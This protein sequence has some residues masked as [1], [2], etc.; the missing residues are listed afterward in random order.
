MLSFLFS[1]V[2]LL[3]ILANS[4]EKKLIELRAMTS[5]KYQK[6]SL[7]IKAFLLSIL[8]PIKLYTRLARVRVSIVNNRPEYFYF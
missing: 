2:T 6:A 1:K 4:K 7:V 3:Q 8:P 5:N